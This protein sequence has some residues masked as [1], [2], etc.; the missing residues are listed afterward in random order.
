MRL[1]FQ[2]TFELELLISCQ[3]G[4]PSFPPDCHVH[5]NSNNHL[6]P[7]GRGVPGRWHQVRSGSDVA[8]CLVTSKQTKRK[9]STRRP[10][11]ITWELDFYFLVKEIWE[12]SSVT[13]PC[14]RRPANQGGHW[15]RGTSKRRAGIIPKHRLNGFHGTPSYRLTCLPALLFPLI[16]R[17]T[18]SS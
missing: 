3:Y 1:E 8:G 14:Y 9:A 5:W 12:E 6:T 11:A 4:C 13:H 16:N 15:E 2:K 7:S 18:V 10:S 17:R